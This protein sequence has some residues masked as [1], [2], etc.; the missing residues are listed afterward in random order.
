MEAPEPER[1]LYARR[2]STGR[3]LT[4]FDSS[5]EQSSYAIELL[6][7]PPERRKCQP[8]RQAAKKPGTHQPDGHRRRESGLTGYGEHPWRGQLATQ[9]QG[10]AQQRQRR[11]R[12]HLQQCCLGWWVEP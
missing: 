2:R 11:R 8:C 7:F 10:L 9:T 3:L 12:H 4:S 6:V 1:S 5:I